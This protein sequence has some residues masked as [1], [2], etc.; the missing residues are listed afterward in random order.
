M[1]RLRRVEKGVPGSGSSSPRGATEVG[2]VRIGG[3]MVGSAVTDEEG[4]REV[5]SAVIE[6]PL[7]T[8]RHKGCF[9]MYGVA[10]QDIIGAPLILKR[11]V[12][13]PGYSRN[14]AGGGAH[15]FF[16]SVMEAV[17]LVSRIDT[18]GASDGGRCGDD[19]SKP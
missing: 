13:S 1:C 7:P 8:P 10:K 14:E 3:T 2:G 16:A 6:I 5:E 12:P 9:T 17:H 19:T 15:D 18:D 11:L 4:G